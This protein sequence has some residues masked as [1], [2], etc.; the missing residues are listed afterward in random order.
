MDLREATRSFLV[1]VDPK[2]SQMERDCTRASR[3]AWMAAAAYGI[4]FR[5]TVGRL[6]ESSC[7]C[8]MARRLVALSAQ[9]SL[10]LLASMVVALFAVIVGSV[11]IVDS[12]GAQ[13]LMGADLL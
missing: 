1:I 13:V 9:N 5:D 11:C 4:P 3:I 8:A 10:K 12:Y 7:N 2:P 6:E